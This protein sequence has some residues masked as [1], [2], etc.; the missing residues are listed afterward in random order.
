MKKILVIDDDED[1]LSLVSH[2]ICREDQLKDEIVFA[3]RQRIEQVLINLLSN[4]IKYSPNEKRVVVRSEKKDDKLIIKV[5][6]SGIGIPP[7]EWE[8]IFGRF[9]RTPQSSDLVS[10]FGL[11]LYISRDIVRR[12]GG[13]MWLE[14]AN[15]GSVFCFSV[16][17]NKTVLKNQPAGE[18]LHHG[19]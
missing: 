10:G 7:D 11:G 17:L 13:D 16:P 4:A 9:Y 3:D 8:N 19:S 5:V 14:H 15:K 18:I 6:D 1:I 12:H 2:E